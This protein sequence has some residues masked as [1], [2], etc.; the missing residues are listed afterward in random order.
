MGETEF[1][2]KYCGL[3]LF[4]NSVKSNFPSAL[5]STVLP[6]KETENNPFI[7]GHGGQ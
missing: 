5:K 1:K 7:C 3:Y 4:F 6:S 2:Y